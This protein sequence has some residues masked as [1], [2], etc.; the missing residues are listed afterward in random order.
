METKELAIVDV[1]SGEVLSIKTATTLQISNYLVDKNTQQ[2][3]LKR[4]VDTIKAYITSNKSKDFKE[5]SDGKL[6]Y[7]DWKI[8]KF[9]K[10][11]LGKKEIERMPIE[12]SELYVTLKGRVKAME[13]KFGVY[14]EVT[15]WN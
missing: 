7:G 15:R 11:T 10:L 3:E 1:K 9:P 8:S 13:E 4:E 2:K 12:A 6:F 14:T 5:E